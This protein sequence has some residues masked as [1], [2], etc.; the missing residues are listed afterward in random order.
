MKDG[1]PGATEA[2]V[3]AGATGTTISQ[4]RRRLSPRDARVVR[5]AGRALRVRLTD[6]HVVLWRLPP[7]G[8]DCEPGVFALDRMKE[9]EPLATKALEHSYGDNR[10]RAIHQLARVRNGLG[11]KQEALA[12]IKGALDETKTPA[13]QA[14]RTHRYLKALAK[15]QTELGG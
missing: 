7:V 8:E 15:L 13:E 5:R 11:K 4:T 2:R 1:I 10:L 9:A 6:P 12:L 14:V 3:Q